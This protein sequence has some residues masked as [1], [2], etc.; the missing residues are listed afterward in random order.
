MKNVKPRMRIMRTDFEFSTRSVQI[1]IKLDQLHGFAKTKALPGDWVTWRLDPDS[2]AQIG[3]V[4]GAAL[5]QDGHEGAMAHYLMV[6]GLSTDATS[7][8]MN[9]VAPER[10]TRCLPGPPKAVMEFL[11][12]T[13]DDPQTI[14]DRI[15]GGI[16]EDWMKHPRV[17]GEKS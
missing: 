17:A 11:C 3:R 4:I 1:P 13:W 6:A 8:T 2:R 15:E 14:C 5:T 10:V 16:L 12:G 9:W 7:V